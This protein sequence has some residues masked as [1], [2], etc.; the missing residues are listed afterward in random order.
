MHEVRYK[1]NG[2]DGECT[3]GSKSVVEIRAVIES[4]C[5]AH[6]YFEYPHTWKDYLNELDYKLQENLLRISTVLRVF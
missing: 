1:Y 4:T 2:W 6:S 3:I 5:L